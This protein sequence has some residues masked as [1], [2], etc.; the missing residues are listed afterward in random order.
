MVIYASERL[1]Q[2][3]ADLFLHLTLVIGPGAVVVVLVLVVY[4]HTFGFF[5]TFPDE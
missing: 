3:M 5:T 1:N 4:S 2:H